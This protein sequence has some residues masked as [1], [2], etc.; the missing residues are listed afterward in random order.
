MN[1]TN[2]TSKMS[3]ELSENGRFLFATRDS[4]RSSGVVEELT[5][6]SALIRWDNTGN[7]VWY[8]LTMFKGT[9]YNSPKYEI[10][11]KLKPR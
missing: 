7:S 8:A 3:I 6:T 10:I 1:N 4:T 5:E 2:T 9:A 11:E